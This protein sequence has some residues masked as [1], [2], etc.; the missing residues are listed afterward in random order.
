MCFGILKN[1]YILYNKYIRY[2]GTYI[3]GS[4]K[5]DTIVYS[6]KYNTTK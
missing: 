5:L 1:M 6:L 4:I 3:Y 2:L